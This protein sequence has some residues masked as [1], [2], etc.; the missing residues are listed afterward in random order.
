MNVKSLVIVQGTGSKVG[1]ADLYC[2]YN[3]SSTSQGQR[4]YVKNEGANQ[5]TD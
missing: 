3:V 2:G 4:K 5:P 1:H